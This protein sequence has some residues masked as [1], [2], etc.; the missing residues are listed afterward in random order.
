MKII[1]EVDRDMFY[2][3]GAVFAMIF[4]LGGAAIGL[5]FLIDWFGWL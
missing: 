4:Y 3:F 5:L 1:N 2:I